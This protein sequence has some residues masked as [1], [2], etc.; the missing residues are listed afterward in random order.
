MDSVRHR[1]DY[2]FLEDVG[3]SFWETHSILFVICMFFF[4][5]LTMLFGTTMGGGI[6]YW[7]GWVLAPRI[8]VAVLATYFFGSTNTLLVVL[9]WFWAIAG[10][11]VEKS[12]ASQGGCFE[13]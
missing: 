11:S 10:E 12:T 9:T 5:R 1:F 7:V 4:P 6:L 3:M 13:H 8:T 2:L